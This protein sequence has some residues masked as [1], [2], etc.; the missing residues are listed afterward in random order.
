MNVVVTC[1]QM[2]KLLIFQKPKAARSRH[3]IS[4]QTEGT[5]LNL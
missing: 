4:I 1:A 3:T 5:N 2:S